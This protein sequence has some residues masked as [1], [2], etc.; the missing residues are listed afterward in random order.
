MALEKGGDLLD[1]I[2]YA[3]RDRRWVLAAIQDNYPI[4]QFDGHGR[5]ALS[6][7]AS[8]GF[9]PEVEALIRRGAHSQPDEN[10]QT[11]LILAAIGGH[12]EVIR[13]LAGEGADIDARDKKGKTAIM[14]AAGGGRAN[15]A[16]E[17]GKLGANINAREKDTG[18]T[19][20]MLAAEAGHLHV[21]R[22]LVTLQA[23]LDATDEDGKTAAQ[24]ALANGHKDITLF[25]IRQGAKAPALDFNTETQEATPVFSK[26]LRMLRKPTIG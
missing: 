1:A 17:L 19:P 5:N 11:P 21:I 16:L 9:L 7:C 18:R 20:L 15:A 8:K 13:A 25:L 22:D 12:Y 10:G 2:M 26:P 3:E 6:W 14:L 24:I 23:A 4:D